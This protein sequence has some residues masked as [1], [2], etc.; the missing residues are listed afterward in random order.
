MQLQPSPSWTNRIPPVDRHRV[1]VIRPA[2]TIQQRKENYN[3]SQPQEPAVLEKLKS[4]AQCE[5]SVGSFVS[6]IQ[7]R[8]PILDWLPTYSPTSSLLGDIIAGVTVAIMHIPQGI[9]YALLASLPPIC[10]M[11]MAFF[12]VL[13]YVL[14]GTSRHCSMGTFPIVCIMTGKVVNELATFEDAPSTANMKIFSSDGSSNGYTAIQVATT[15]AFMSGVWEFILGLLQLGSLSVF[16]SDMLISGF[17]TGAAVHVV[18]SQVNYLFGL[19]IKR[20]NGPLKIIYTYRDLFSNLIEANTVTMI[21]SLITIIVLVFNNEMIKPRLRK[22]TAFPIPIELI[23][24]VL[25]TVASN[26]GDFNK[27][28]EMRVVGEI[29]TGL[30]KPE[31]PPMEL[32]PSVMV[33]S[34]VITI[35]GYTVSYSMSKI[36]AKKHNYAVDA[37]QELYALGMSNIFG[38]FF[39]CAP[40]APSMSRSLIQ[41]SVGGVTQIASLISCV[42]M[43]FVLLFIGPVFGALPNCVLS[44]IILVALKGMFL[45]FHDL[46]TQ[47]KLSKIDATIWICTFLGVVIV[48]IDYGLVIGIIVSLFVLLAR[49]QKPVTARLG[50]IPN[51]DIYLDKEKYST[52][53]E[54]PGVT[55]FQFSGSVHFANIEYFRTRLFEATLLG[56]AVINY[57]N[58]AY[59]ENEEKELQSNIKD[60]SHPMNNGVLDKK[61]SKSKCNLDLPNSSLSVN[62]TIPGEPVLILDLG[63]MNFVDTPGA[64][65]LAQLYKDYNEAGITLAFAQLSEN[66]YHTLEKCGSLKTIHDHH[67]FHSV[68]DAVVKLTN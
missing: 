24:V 62:I 25:G 7:S 26:F 53:V 30:P 57:A 48:D 23:T 47:W 66:A 31:A 1:S 52:V 28:Y 58:E 2:L 40:M 56:P 29:P 46:V 4:A 18:T 36:F 15:V 45:Q 67:I 41:E 60:K 14:F 9:A 54:V 33:D 6:S 21:T 37:T 63:G 42:L 20:Y 59:D 65:F 5:C 32:V 49:N 64:K 11:Y 10:G 27:N 34:F 50:H 3:Y 8:L 51:T 55:I 38:S 19:N 68:H 44:A 35:V 22:K 12:P 39:S 16:L 61:S 17:T 13:I 43:L